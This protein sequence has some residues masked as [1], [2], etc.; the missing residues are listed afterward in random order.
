MLGYLSNLALAA[1]I[2]CGFMFMFWWARPLFLIPLT[3]VY[4]LFVGSFTNIFYWT[5]TPYPH[6]M[7]SFIFNFF[8]VILMVVE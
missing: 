4:G 1:Y 6:A 2:G 3:I 8:N 5:Y 7:I